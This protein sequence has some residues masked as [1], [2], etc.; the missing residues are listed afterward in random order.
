MKQYEKGISWTVLLLLFI[1]SILYNIIILLL[2]SFNEK[3]REEEYKK[4]ES[5]K[6][7]DTTMSKSDVPK[8]R[9]K[10]RK[11]EKLER[12]NEGNE[13]RLIFIISYIWLWSNIVQYILLK[14]TEF[15]RRYISIY[16]FRTSRSDEPPSENA[17]LCVHSLR[18]R[19]RWVVFY[20][21][22]RETNTWKHSDEP[23]LKGMFW[24]S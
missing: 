2:Y 1:Y 9:K 13:M 17:F 22:E 14:K 10:E 23:N 19:P 24:H 15:I 8:E 7:D 3:I 4:E 16:I 6:F 20:T 18:H 11:K 21:N 5:K 12:K